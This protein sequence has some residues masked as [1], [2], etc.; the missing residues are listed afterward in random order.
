MSPTSAPITVVE[1][2]QPVLGAGAATT[3]TELASA[4]AGQ[5]LVETNP[6]QPP[7]QAAVAVAALAAIRDELERNTM[8]RNVSP[9]AA[10][11]AS[12]ES[13]NVLLIGVDGTNLSK[14][15]SDPANANFF[16]L[17]QEST[18]APSSIVGHTTISN[19]SWTSILTGVWGE[20]TGV[21]N[22]IFT[23]WTY[24]NYPTVFNQL[25][26]AHGNG[27]QTTAIANW[28][29]IA[30]IAA[31]GANRADTIHYIGPE[32]SWAASDD[33]VGSVTG[34]T[35]AAADRDVANFVFSY[36]VGVDEAGHAFGGGS[37][38]YTDALL[39]FDRNLGLIMQQVRDW[40]AANGETWTVILVT[41]HGHQPQ[42]GLGHGFQSPDETGTFV[43]VRGEGFGGSGPGNG[44]INLQYEIVDVTPTVVTLFGGT[45]RPGSDG[46][47]M[48]E[49]TN[50]VR[51]IDNDDALRAALQDIIGKNGYPDIATDVALGIRT[52][53]ASIPYFLVDIV[54]GI[55]GGLKAV[56]G[57][58]IFL[59]SFLAGA[60]VGPVEFIGDL[61]YVVTNFAAQI[62]ARITGV[63]G[64][65]IFPLWPP[66]APDFTPYD[67]DQLITMVAV[68]GDP[69]AAA[70]AQCPASIAV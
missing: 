63:T 1:T 27:I 14:V 66:A 16:T 59:V 53:F 25:E 64:A 50:N 49:L 15:L 24:D 18:T 46:T 6:E 44:L 20:R 21:I 56:A 51:P 35:I 13:K 23:P 31:A 58:N 8:R 67:P 9:A 33:L 26:G 4:A 42:R 65:S 68:C 41:D 12:P 5:P 10:T 69:S 11:A 39:N 61:G 40:E 38:E 32:S 54:D 60:A 70:S 2:A 37:Q 43:I 3:P 48:T 52:I 19:P 47:S 34:A 62:V 17:I 55:V 29:V 22:N 28:D 7:L 57:Q 30:A 45:V 36:F